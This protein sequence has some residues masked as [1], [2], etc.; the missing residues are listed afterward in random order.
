MSAKRVYSRFLVTAFVPFILQE[1][2]A[3]FDQ[4]TV[5]PH[6]IL[7]VIIAKAIRI[8]PKAWHGNV[9]LRVDFTGCLE[10]IVAQ[11]VCSK[12]IFTV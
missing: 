9:A 12:D 2:L 4:H 10:G 8:H 3:N 11:C 5:V 1:F 6:D 7:P